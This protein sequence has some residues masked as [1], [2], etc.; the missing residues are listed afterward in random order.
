MSKGPWT[1][2]AKIRNSAEI[3]RLRAVQKAKRDET[4]RRILMA[5]EE[6]DD[7]L[8]EAQIAKKIDMAQS[9]VE[10]ALHR[11]RSNGF[12]RKCAERRRAGRFGNLACVYEL[13][14]EA[15]TAIVRAPVM[16][17]PFRHPQDVALFGEYRRAA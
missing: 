16:F 7:P 1:K 12:V 15:E 13:G 6:S 17:T 4:D 5:L 2:G 8:S 10:K 11:L 9:T 14:D 3:N